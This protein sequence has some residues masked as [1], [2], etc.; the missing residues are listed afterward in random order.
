LGS[1]YGG[2]KVRDGGEMDGGQWAL[3]WQATYV[4][5]RMT[6]CGQQG[7][8]LR[9]VEFFEKAIVLLALVREFERVFLNQN[10]SNDP[11]RNA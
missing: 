6:S 2:G 9:D 4:R 1:L 3:R 5:R 7:E 11:D 10:H 8:S